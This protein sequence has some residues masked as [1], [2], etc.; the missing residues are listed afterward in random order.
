MTGKAG[1][2]LVTPGTPAIAACLEVGKLLTS[3][4]DLREILGRIMAELSRLIPARNWSLLL[5]NAETGGLSFEIF[6]GPGKEQVQGL[7]MARGEGI[8]GHVAETGEALFIPDARRDPRFARRVDDQTGFVTESILCVPLRFQGTVLGVIEVVN[9]KDFHAFENTYLPTLNI[10]A[11]YAAIA[12]QNAQFCA[13]IERMSLTDEYTG[14]YNARFLHQALDE[15]IRKAEEEG[16]EIG[17]VFVDVDNF[18]SVVDDY[19]HLLGSQVLREM[20]QTIHSCLSA[21]DLLVKYGGDEFV[22][23]LPGRSRQE[24]RELVEKILQA[25]RSS[26]YLN[27]EPEPVR[28]TASFGI[29]MFPENARTKKDLLL[30]ADKAMYEVKSSTKNAVGLCGV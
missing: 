30:L 19:G 10:L 18:K 26:I 29:A 6:V 7:R 2:Q 1:H 3:S 14:L 25:I 11:D 12:I 16:R 4:L 15:L 23:L 17:V 24:A 22:I 27:S 20:G 9:L 8:A 13:R 5:R 28:V 21:C